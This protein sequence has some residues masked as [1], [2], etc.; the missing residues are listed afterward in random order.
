LLCLCK[1]SSPPSSENDDNFFVNHSDRGYTIS[2]VAP[3]LR[4]DA[5]ARMYVSSF[6]FPVPPVPPPRTS[7][8][9]SP[10]LVKDLAVQQGQ[11]TKG[12]PRSN[13][14]S[15]AM[16][17][18]APQPWRDVTTTKCRGGMADGPSRGSARSARR[19]VS[20]T[21]SR[22]S[23]PAG[24]SGTGDRR[25]RCSR[26]WSARGLTSTA[27]MCMRRRGRWS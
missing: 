6:P 22:R 17:D 19:A 1:S 12:A 24:A 8:S 23:V 21:A 11:M 16:S 27:R 20:A 18:A 5:F 4:N 7:T 2:D 3:L 26:D 25:A 10:R 9:T 15:I 14:N 13:A